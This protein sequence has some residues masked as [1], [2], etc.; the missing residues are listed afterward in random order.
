M[1]IT[2]HRDLNGHAAH[3]HDGT[4]TVH[5]TAPGTPAEARAAAKEWIATAGK[6][7]GFGG[8]RQKDEEIMTQHVTRKGA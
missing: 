3:V 6:L 4:R 1:T 7:R 8:R 5:I 2:I